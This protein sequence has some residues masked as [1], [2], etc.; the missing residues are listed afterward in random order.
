MKEKFQKFSVDR[1]VLK[2]MTDKPPEPQI[3]GSK[4]AFQRAEDSAFHLGAPKTRRS[5]C[6]CD[7]FVIKC[8]YDPRVCV[9]G[10]AF[11]YRHARSSRGSIAGEKIRGT[12]FTRY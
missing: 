12:R 3:S 4:A 6:R 2:T 5:L 11:R 10:R 8:L 1:L 9:A 7:Y